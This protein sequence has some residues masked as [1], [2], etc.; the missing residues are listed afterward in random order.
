MSREFGSD[1]FLVAPNIQKIF[2]VPEEKSRP[3]SR[4]G[5][6]PSEPNL[7]HGIPFAEVTFPEPVI[8]LHTDESKQITELLLKKFAS[9]VE[10]QSKRLDKLRS[11]NE[12][13]ERPAS[14]PFRPQLPRQKVRF[15]PFLFSTCGPSAHLLLFYPPLCL[16]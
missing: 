1:I 15:S 6:P 8:D 14:N 5:T 4:P 12:A 16:F 3:N 11:S 2:R 7:V 10:E 13:F 9:S